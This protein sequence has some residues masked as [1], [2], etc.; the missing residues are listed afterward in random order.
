MERIYFITNYS[1]GSACEDHVPQ[2]SV[3]SLWK[4]DTGIITKMCFYIQEIYVPKFGLVI[5]S[6]NPMCSKRQTERGRGSTS[7]KSCL[8]QALG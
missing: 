2:K 3:P 6:C 8:L 1:Q 5:A 7:N 4:V